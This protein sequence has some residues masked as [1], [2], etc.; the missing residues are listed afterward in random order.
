MPHLQKGRCF[1]KALLEINSFIVFCITFQVLLVSFM[2]SYF[3]FIVRVFLREIHIWYQ[4]IP[5][6]VVSGIFG[7]SDGTTSIIGK[8]KVL[9][10]LM[11]HTYK[12]KEALG[13]FATKK[14]GENLISKPVSRDF[15]SVE[16]QICKRKKNP[17]FLGRLPLRWR[18]V[19]F[20]SWFW[21]CHLWGFPCKSNL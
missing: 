7:V 10:F 13:N 4:Q 11:Y 17:G 19:H 3:S 6:W 9:L 14:R 16:S 5:H 15:L 12:N 8:M 18:Q 21:K 20:L 1:R 2:K